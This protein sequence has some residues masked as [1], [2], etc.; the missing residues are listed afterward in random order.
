M[1]KKPKS[2]AQELDDIVFD[3]MQA[4]PDPVWVPMP[5]KEGEPTCGV[6]LACFETHVGLFHGLQC[7]EAWVAAKEEDPEAF[8]IDVAEADLLEF[9]QR[10]SKW[11]A[12]QVVN[13]SERLDIYRQLS[14][15]LLDQD[16]EEKMKAIS[17]DPME[18]RVSWMALTGDT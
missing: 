17:D 14:K 16:A 12:D 7:R 5:P 4:Q 11:L 6:C 15:M 10:R 18:G 3:T 9:F 8:I 2:R 1:S 13:V